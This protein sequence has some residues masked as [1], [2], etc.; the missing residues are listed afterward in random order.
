MPKLA[1]CKTQITS[2]W[3]TTVSTQREKLLNYCDHLQEGKIVQNYGTQGSLH[4]D[5]SLILVLVGH[6]G[7]ENVGI[8]G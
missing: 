3:K 2:F 6:L 7:F 4:G 1:G 5:R 8:G